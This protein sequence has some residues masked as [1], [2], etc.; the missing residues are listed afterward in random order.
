M[1]VR[2]D[3][4]VDVGQHVDIDDTTRARDHRPFL[5]R[6]REDRVHQARRAVELDEYRRMSEQ[7]DSHRRLPQGRTS[8]LHPRRPPW[9]P[10]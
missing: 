5:E 7:R 10:E 3:E 4:D 8:S 6:I 2:D 1:T 9:H